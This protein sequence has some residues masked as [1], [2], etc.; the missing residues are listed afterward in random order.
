[1]SNA[2]LARE[3]RSG[4]SPRNEV[5]VEGAIGSNVSLQEGLTVILKLP[6]FREPEL[7]APLSGQTTRCRA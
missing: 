6:P 7:A 2:H 1:M 3:I 4:L 5:E